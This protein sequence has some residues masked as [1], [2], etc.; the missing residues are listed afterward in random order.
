MRNPIIAA[1]AELARAI[2]AEH[3][4]ASIARGIEAAA[5]AKRRQ[6]EEPAPPRL[7]LAGA[8]PRQRSAMC[9]AADELAAR[10]RREP[11]ALRGWR[12]LDYAGAL[13]PGCRALCTL[14][15]LRPE[16]RTLRLACD[17]AGRVV[18]VA[19]D[20]R[21]AEALSIAEAARRAK[22]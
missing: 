15:P 4:A 13:P 8:G 3:R 9:S 14:L 16:G 20:G 1:G 5:R 12:R 2:N 18:A 22:G 21:S 19:G 10:E 17:L 7:D 11:A 6:A